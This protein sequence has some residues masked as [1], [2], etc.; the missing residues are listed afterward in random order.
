MIETESLEVQFARYFDVQVARD[1][2]L[3]DLCYRMRY[4][5]YCEE[6][7][8]ESPQ[9]FPDGRETDDYDPLALSCVILHR[10]TGQLAGSLRL[11]PGVFAGKAL[12]LPFELTRSVALEG[13]FSGVEVLDRSTICEV[14][15]LAVGC[16]FRRRDGEFS[17][18]IGE[19]TSLDPDHAEYRCFNVV[20]EAIFLAGVALASIVG[21]TNMFAMME[22]VLPRILRRSGINFQQIGECVNYHGLRA[23]FFA[24]TA[25]VESQI[26]T[27]LQPLYRFLYSALKRSYE[28]QLAVC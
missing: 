21:S 4:R 16:A 14:S 23:P 6:F 3:K 10:R 9:A 12:D 25:V 20:S 22:P 24:N 15:R 18:R 17:S 1:E 26:K 11:I 2:T 28:Q 5:V 19:Q 27:G 7:G 8:Y 13:E